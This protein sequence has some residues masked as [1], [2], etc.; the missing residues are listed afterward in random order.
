MKYE[1][2]KIIDVVKY[3]NAELLKNR[4][5]K[6][7]EEMDFGE[8][9]GVIQKRLNR[10]GYVKANNQFILVNN[11]T[12]TNTTNKIQ[13]NNA[14][15]ENTNILQN[16]KKEDDKR[17]FKKDEIEKLDRLLKLDVDI[18]EEMIKEHTTKENIKSS[19]HIKDNS[20]IVTSIRVNK[21]LYLEVKQ[22]AKEKDIKLQDIFF[23]MMIEY[24]NK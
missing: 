3:V 13:K 16:N 7:I 6:D 24:L 23:N 1:E 8:N 22:R 19:I 11:D 17:T 12:T 14:T 20:T 2:M 15:N 18:L 10:K 21:E 4:T 5:M 9:K